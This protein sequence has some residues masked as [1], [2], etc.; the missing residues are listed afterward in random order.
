MSPLYI[1]DPTAADELSKVRGIGRFMQI[2]HENISDAAFIS[3]IKN[4]PFDSIFLNPFFN[5]L[6]APLITKR[7]AKK[8]MVMIHDVIPLKHPREFPIGIRGMIN[9]FRNKRS[10]KNY[11]VILTNSEASKQDIINILK[12]DPKKI[13]VM[14]PITAEIFRKASPQNQ[15]T[16]EENSPTEIIN[17]Q[18]C[19]YVGD[20]TWNKN[21][22]NLAK[23]I[24]IAD[25]HCVFVGKVFSKAPTSHP[26]QKEL[27]H[28]FQET[29]NDPRYVFPGY[30]PDDVLI[31]LYKNAFCN[32]LVSRDEGFGFSF[33]EAAAL[34]VP[35]ILSD[36]PAL[37][38]TAANCALFAN[39]EDPHDIAEKL[40]QMKTD[41]IVRKQFADAAYERSKEFSPEKLK[42]VFQSACAA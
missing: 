14:Y 21:L 30:I 33:V 1:Y 3:D 31:D 24:Q 2:L 19:I 9:V 5:M 27:L 38:E 37:R 40:K 8:Q 28:F 36:I 23:A 41:T 13:H 10:L 22:V 34:R 11:D 32:V 17:S 35:S 4:V 15:K 18:Y 25:V 7:I 6:A 42:K 12:L 26:W 29:K 39:A 20:G 16:T